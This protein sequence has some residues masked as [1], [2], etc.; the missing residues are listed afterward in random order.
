MVLVYLKVLILCIE[1]IDRLK[2][3]SEIPE[4]KIKFQNY[5]LLKLDFALKNKFWEQAVFWQCWYFG[6]WIQRAKMLRIQRIRIL[7]A[8]PIRTLGSGSGFWIHLMK[9]Y[10]N[11]AHEIIRL[12]FVC[13]SWRWNFIY[14]LQIR[15]DL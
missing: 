6:T 10:P 13:K 12:L 15:K 14:H 5:V 3:V 11:S 2:I 1:W 9:N 8:L 4:P 7:Y